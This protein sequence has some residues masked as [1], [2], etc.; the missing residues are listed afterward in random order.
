[1]RLRWIENFKIIE[2]LRDVLYMRCPIPENAL[3]P[4]VRLW[5]L[6]DG[7][8]SGGLIITVHSGNEKPDKSWSCNHLFARSL[9][10]PAN[11]SVPQ[12]ELHVLNSLA[13][14]ADIL[15]KSL[16]DW[17]E[18]ILYGSDSKQYMRK[19]NSIFSTG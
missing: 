13:N 6:C 5:L 4:T 15:N 1:M 11:W 16:G 7:A 19:S 18:L 3:R 17:L 8:P 9:L 10:A 14:I 2:D 12:L